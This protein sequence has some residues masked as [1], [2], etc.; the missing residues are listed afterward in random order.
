MKKST[1]GALAA[2]AAGVLLL[3]GAG[4]LAYW[5][6][7]ELVTGGTVNA[8]H[9]A[10]LTDAT[11]TGCGSWTLDSGESLPTTYTAG[12]PL[13]PG[14]VLSKSCAFTIDAEGNHLRATIAADTPTLTG[15]L[16]DSLDIGTANLEVNGSP[17]TEFTETNDGQALTV[18]VTVTF[19]STVTGDMDTSAV[20]GDITVT[21]SQIHS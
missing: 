17:A 15:D 7:S 18:D 16:A 10:L 20:L 2:T 21:A 6:D 19:D 4:T 12:D 14:D 8:G 11:N 5:S 9:L 13:V 1:K 3:G